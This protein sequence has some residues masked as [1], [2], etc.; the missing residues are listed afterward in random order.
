MNKFSGFLDRWRGGEAEQPI[1]QGLS[2][3]NK[4]KQIVC[5]TISQSPISQWVQLSVIWDLPSLKRVVT[6]FSS[7]CSPSIGNCWNDQLINHRSNAESGKLLPGLDPRGKHTREGGPT[8]AVAPPQRQRHLHAQPGCRPLQ[9][10]PGF[11]ANPNGFKI[12]I[13]VNIQVYPL[14]RWTKME[15]VPAISR[16]A[17]TP[18]PPMLSKLLPGAI[19]FDINLTGSKCS[20]FCGE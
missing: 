6:C 20:N 10:H 18:P 8:L 13:Q 4:V 19:R 2:I 15:G 1:L 14:S 5:S 9:G 7:I 11:R 17:P 12:C 3:W 16:T